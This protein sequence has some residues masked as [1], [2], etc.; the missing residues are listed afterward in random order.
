M[1]CETGGKWP[2]NC[3]FVECC[4]QYLF[5]TVC[6]ILVKFPSS[7]FFSKHF[8]WS[9]VVQP[10]SC[11]D[12]DFDIFGDH[13]KLIR[14]MPK[15]K[16]VVISITY[17]KNIPLLGTSA[18]ISNVKLTWSSLSHC[19]TGLVIIIIIRR[20][21]RKERKV[22]GP[23]LRTKKAKEHESNGYSNCNWHDGNG[24]RWLRG[25]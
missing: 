9:P 13:D 17:W 7:F 8:V 19:L 22:L 5:K 20:R 16:F 18:K 12:T 11:T 15:Q 23:C 6:S 21:R 10:Y 24:S 4:F 1:A 2:Y 3:C 25:L 14:F